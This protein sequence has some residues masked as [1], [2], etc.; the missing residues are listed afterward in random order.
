SPISG[1]SRTWTPFDAQVGNVVQSGRSFASLRNHP[2]AGRCHSQVTR[3]GAG[4]FH[5][6]K[7]IASLKQPFR[8]SAEQVIGNQRRRSSRVRVGPDRTR[9]QRAGHPVEGALYGQP[10]FRSGKGDRGLADTRD[11]GDT[12]AQAADHLAL[13]VEDYALAYL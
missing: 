12:L 10:S 3:P 1:A 13:E 5:G 7:V 6:P 8:S 4:R 9:E 11:L 2:I